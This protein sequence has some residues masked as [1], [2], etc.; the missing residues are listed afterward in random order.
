ML[1]LLFR[2]NHRIL[3]LMFHGDIHRDAREITLHSRLHPELHIAHLTWDGTAMPRDAD[4]STLWLRPRLPIILVRQRKSL[5]CTRTKKICR[6][7][8]VTK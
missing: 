5:I 8:V 1:L 6:G 7:P 2:I 4:R 3:I